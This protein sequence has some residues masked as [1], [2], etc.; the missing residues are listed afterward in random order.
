MKDRK[1]PTTA[2]GMRR[3]AEDACRQGLGIVPIAR[4]L[5]ADQFRTFADKFVFN[6]DYSTHAYVTMR[7]FRKRCKR[8]L[9]TAK[10]IRGRRSDIIDDNRVI[11]DIVTDVW[12]ESRHACW[13]C[14]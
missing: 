1:Y 8:A 11:V 6:G 4:K 9:V 2:G 5:T 12:C 14:L 7:M 10:T 3:L 13:S